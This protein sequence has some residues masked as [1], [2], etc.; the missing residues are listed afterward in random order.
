M[1]TLNVSPSLTDQVYRAIV[2]EILEGH[3]LPG[4]HL[5]QEQ[6]ATDLGVSR[7]PIQQAMA[8][9]KAD[10]M[11]EDV[12]RRGLRVASLDLSRM[13]CHYDIRGLLDGYAARGAAD[14]IRSGA[15]DTGKIK[16][17]LDEI[18]EGRTKAIQ[19]QSVKDQI[20]YDESFHKLIYD[21]SGN[22]VLRGTIEPHW[23][24]MRLVM[25]EVLM[26]AEPATVVWDQHQLIADAVLS[27]DAESAGK[28]AEDHVRTAT[29]RLTEA[30]ERKGAALQKQ[31]SVA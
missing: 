22:S 15:I 17:Q 6:L 18:F 5:V 10:G 31:T 12:G 27:G 1:K 3:L 30:M 29:R 9:L 28:L 11:V 7:Q 14:V 26:H 2:D 4:Q 16:Q 19:S 21:Y 24:Y 13:R 20:H 8:L 25:R 23:R